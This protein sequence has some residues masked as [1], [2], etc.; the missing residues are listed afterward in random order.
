VVISD[1][2]FQHELDYIHSLRGVVIKIV[3]DTKIKSDHESENGIDSL[4][5]DFLILNDD[6]ISTLCFIINETMK[7]IRLSYNMVIQ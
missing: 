6:T 4:V 7:E 5:C 2:R 3:R 1:V